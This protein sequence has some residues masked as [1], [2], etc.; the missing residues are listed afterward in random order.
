MTD[1][2]TEHDLLGYREALTAT[3]ASELIGESPS[4]CAFHLRTLAKYGFLR[5]A[6]GSNRRER[7]WTLAYPSGVHINPRP[8][9]PQATLAAGALI[10][11][12]LG[13]WLSR[14]GQVF[15][16]PSRVPGWEKVPGW[17]QQHV[18]MTPDEALA[19]QAEVSK[20]L[21][22]FEARQL[23][24]E[25]MNRLFTAP[26]TAR[27]R[28]ASARTTNGSEPP[29]SRRLFLMTRPAASAT[30]APARSLPVRLTAATRSS[31]I[32]ARLTSGTSSSA[33]TMLRKTS[34]GRPASRMTRSIASAHPVTFGECLRTA[35]LPASS[36]GT[37][38]A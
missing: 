13:R 6:A 4:N 10:R 17:S 25:L 12:I 5:E 27:S 20:V 37:R 30:A 32:S 21:H 34:A 11:T 31:S 8:G 1:V 16:S 28:S 23:C 2:R 7:P 26:A 29:S 19:A 15:G 9:D 22:R 36:D 18:F 3:E 24:P 33:T 35:V 38:P 14:A